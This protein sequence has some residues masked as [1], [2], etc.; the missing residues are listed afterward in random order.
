MA[1]DLFSKYYNN[2]TKSYIY[3]DI[4]CSNGDSAD[5]LSFDINESSGE[6]TD[7]NGVLSSIDLSD[8][9]VG[10][11]QYASNSRILQPNEFCYIRGWLF[12]DSYCSKSYGRIIG[13]ITEDEDWMYKG[14]IFFVIKYLNLKTGNKVIESIKCTG[15]IDEEIT[16]I[17][18]MNNYFEEREIPITVTFD[19]GYVV[20]TATKLDYEFWVSHVMFWNS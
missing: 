8:I 16:F 19:D 7:N 15:N 18:A 13:P 14:L 9:H 12:G 20:F 2:P 10:L 6:I 1:T 11:S 5:E 17:D 4:L 3:A